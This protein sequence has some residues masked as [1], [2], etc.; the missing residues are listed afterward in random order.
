MK[1]PRH[2]RLLAPSELAAIQAGLAPLVLAWQQS[3]LPA[4]PALP[5]TV[6]VAV[7]AAVVGMDCRLSLLDQSGQVCAQ[8][9]CAQGALD[10]LQERSGL[11]APDCAQQSG[12]ARKATLHLL[13]DLLARLAKLP[14]GSAARDSLFSQRQERLPLPHACGVVS[15]N[16]DLGAGVLQVLLT[17]AVVG[18]WCQSLPAKRGGLDARQGLA[19]RLTLRYRVLAGS[20]ELALADLVQLEPGDVLRFDH[21]AEQGLLL[22][23]E[24]GEAWCRAGIGLH[25]GRP[26]LQVCGD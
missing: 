17:Q 20:A 18:R 14:A 10:A 13:G 9:S 6:Q 3:C 23:S 16:V 4:G 8:L 22:A 25:Q 24:A 15:L 7:D 19:D 5:C 2:W 11:G 21:S 12:M 26:V 1:K